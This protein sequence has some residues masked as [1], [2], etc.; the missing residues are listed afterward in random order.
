VTV[1]KLLALPLAFTGGVILAS[2][3][4]CTETNDNHCAAKG[5][6]VFCQEKT[7]KAEGEVFCTNNCGGDYDFDGCLVAEDPPADECWLCDGE[8]SA[9][10]GSIGDGDGD[11]T[12]TETTADTDSTD[13][14]TETMETET[15]AE[16]GP[17]CM[18]NLGCP[19]EMPLCDDGACVGCGDA[20][21]VSCS[22]EFPDTPACDAASGGC[23]ECTGEDLSACSAGEP[24]CEGG[25]CVPC[26]E[27]EQCPDSACNMATGACMPTNRVWW[28]N[29]TVAGP[30]MGTAM[31]PYKEFAPALNNIGAGEEGVIY[32]ATPGTHTG[33]VQVL[34]NRT[35]AILGKTLL[36]FVQFSGAPAV[37]ANQNST[38]FLHRVKVSGGDDLGV[39][40][41][42]CNLWLTESKIVKNSDGDISVLSGNVKI[43]NS[44]V[45][46]NLANFPAV[47]VSLGNVE[48]L[49]STVVGGGISS[50]AISCVDGNGVVV[51]N[52]LIVSAQAADEIDCANAQILSNALEM[53]LP[54]NTSLGMMPGLGWFEDYV[55]GDFHLVADFAPIEI[56]TSAIWQLGDPRGDIE[57]DARPV[58]DMATDYAGADVP[59]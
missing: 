50:E 22:S 8:G 53:V 48:V 11:T 34:G 16:T 28:V 1:R 32:F 3:A 36:G 5:G 49:Y 23:V 6:D 44:F 55:E 7:G 41:S 13:D 57:G 42:G 25:V 4:G 46:G 40:C 37:D 10:C 59:N 24:A 43:I 9:N 26:D 47:S 39:R 14:A 29:Q 2:F 35:V 56:A 18:D 45:G 19:G 30:G 58:F 51:R 54:G 20:V 38:V 17:E 52:S 15:T 33:Q 27:H 21:G 12:D 31:D